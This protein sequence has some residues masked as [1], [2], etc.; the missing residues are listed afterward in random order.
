M[1]SGGFFALSAEG[2]VTFWAVKVV[3]PLV[4]VGYTRADGRIYTGEGR[5]CTSEG[6]IRTF[7]RSDPSS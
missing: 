7:Q 1:R 3:C 5:V 4:M 6:R 2:L